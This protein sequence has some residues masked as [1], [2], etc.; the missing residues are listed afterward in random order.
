[1]PASGR[2]GPIEID[3]WRCLGHRLALIIG[4]LRILNKVAKANDPS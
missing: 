4:T 2:K 3:G 1:M